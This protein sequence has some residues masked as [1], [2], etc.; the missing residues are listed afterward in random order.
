[1][2]LVA[3]GILPSKVADSKT[4]MACVAQF[5]R[6][7]VG[8]SLGMPTLWELPADFLGPYAKYISLY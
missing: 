2:A 6:A 5:A 3:V 4:G 8:V 7:F 1:M